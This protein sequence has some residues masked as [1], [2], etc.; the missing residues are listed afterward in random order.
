VEALRQKLR[1]SEEKLQS[2]EWLL[3]KNRRGG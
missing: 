1:E 2:V 3:T